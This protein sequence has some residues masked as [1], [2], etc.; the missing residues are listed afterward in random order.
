MLFAEIPGLQEIKDSLIASYTK[1]H[2]AHAQLFNSAVG[3]GG[4]PIALAFTT[5][6]LCQDKQ[7][8][9]ACGVC[10]SCQKM[11]RM[12]HPDVHFY[13]PK[14]A[15]PKPS[16]YEK[17]FAEVLKKWR[18]FAVAKPYGDV[19]DWVNFN[20][21]ENKNVQISKEDSRQLIRTVS[22]KSFEG[23]FKI[24]IIWYPEFMHPSAA[25]GILKVLEEPPT[26]TIYLL[27]SYAYDNLLATIKSRTQ[28][29]NIP[30]FKEEAIKNYLIGQ[31]D[32][33]PDLAEKVSRIAGGSLG[34]ALYEMDNAGSIAY[35]KFQ[36]WMR[37]CL[38]GSYTELIK[39]SDE[40]N[41]SAKPA[42]RN[43]LEFAISLIREA[44]LSKA[45]DGQLMTREG[46]EGAFI[47]KFGGFASLQALE[48]IYL[49]MS[50]SLHHLQRNANARITFM[51]LSL[52]CSQLLRRQT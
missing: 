29:F 38:S 20:G 30:P 25:N 39:L 52:E 8:Q 48:A 24:L 28:I 49:K 40:F 10:P 1:N 36:S 41:Q 45:T 34:K 2:I 14:P 37:M 26:N 15:P 31:K 7:D 44:I 12:V 11:S 23:D 16:E 3:G 22:M 51:N 6:L 42:Q 50:E 46:E 18:E 17:Q 13:Y 19:D 4:L 9:D 43:E 33:D 32:A 21:Y 27:V 35:Q 47:E 5:Y